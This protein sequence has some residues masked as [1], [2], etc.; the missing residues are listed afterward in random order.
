MSCDEFG[1]CMNR[2][3][4]YLGTICCTGDLS[5]G[6]G[7][8]GLDILNAYATLTA[9]QISHG[10]TTA[11]RCDGDVSCTGSNTI[12]GR[13]I[14]LIA[15]SGGNIYLTGNVAAYRS[16]LITTTWDY[17]IF[18]TGYYSCRLA[19][20]IQHMNNLFCNGYQSCYQSTISFAT[21]IWFY[22]GFSGYYATINYTRGN[23]YCGGFLSCYR[24]DINGA[25]NI[26]ASNYQSLSLSN[27]F[28]VENNVVA[29]GY[30]SLWATQITNVTKVCVTFLFLFC[31]VGNIKQVSY[32]DT[33]LVI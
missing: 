13:K 12:S 30:L 1:E 15:S 4:S 5:C 32:H 21:N 8:T 29:M 10:Q 7:S 14:K 23:I 11:I 19:T 24:S 17:D 28:N 26:F 20:S 9:A 2:N 33:L 16:P 27:I 18:C 3:I 22:G 31:G 6:R 25:Q